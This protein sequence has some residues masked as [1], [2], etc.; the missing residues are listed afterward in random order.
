VGRLEDRRLRELERRMER[1]AWRVA[2]TRLADAD[3]AILN[4][5]GARVVAAD[6]AGVNRPR[7][8]AKERES[9][10]R[11]GAEYERARLEGWGWID[12]PPESDDF[13]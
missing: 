11:W 7:P 13:G 9:L 10:E 4:T 6:N 5:Y 8:T 2:T 12:A 1:A 3:V